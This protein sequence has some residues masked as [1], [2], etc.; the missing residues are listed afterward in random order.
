MT[1]LVA[2]RF[3]HFAAAMI[4]FGG[5]GFDFL[6][7]RPPGIASSA[8]FRRA[9]TL[10]LRGAAVAAALS[11]LTWLMFEAVN[12][13]GETNAA[14]DPATLWLVLSDTSFGTIWLWRIIAVVA[15]TAALFIGDDRLFAVRLALAG[16]T[17]ASLGLVG[18]AAMEDGAF[19]LAHQANHA[20]HLLATGGWVGGLLP[21]A[22]FLCT[23]AGV[24]SIEAAQRFS[25]FGAIVVAA[26]LLSGVTNSWILLHSAADLTNTDYGQLLLAKILLVGV[27]LGFALFHRCVLLPRVQTGTWSL[28]QFRRSVMAEIAVALAVLAIVSVLGTW[29]PQV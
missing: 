20:V 6:L 22:I 23:D 7:R 1:V 27:M 5:L 2:S 3:I 16:L 28:V 17:L 9:M 8:A 11:A 26:V 12:M 13:S 18:H 4:L 19:G 25:A 10:V 15:L 29:P 14:L 24:H 21:L